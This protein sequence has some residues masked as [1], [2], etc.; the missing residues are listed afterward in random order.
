MAAVLT[1]TYWGPT[2]EEQVADLTVTD[3]WTTVSL[4]DEQLTVKSLP[5]K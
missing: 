1:G 4:I 2:E 3:K 5:T